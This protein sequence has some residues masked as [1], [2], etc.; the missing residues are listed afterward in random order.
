MKMKEHIFTVTITELEGK[1]I[2]VNAQFPV[3]L[4]VHILTSTL[5]NISGLLK[6]QVKKYKSKNKDS[7][8]VSDI[9][10]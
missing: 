3:G 4:E 9:S 8:T 5:D 2:E 7:L 10:N 6:K 1:E